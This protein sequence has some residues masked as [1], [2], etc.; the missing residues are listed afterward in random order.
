MYSLPKPMLLPKLP[1]I[2]ST[3][4]QNLSFCFPYKITFPIINTEQI[5]STLYSNT[6]CPTHVQ[7]IYAKTASKTNFLLFQQQ[8]ITKFVQLNIL[9]N[10]NSHLLSHRQKFFL[11][12]AF[13]QKK[14]MKLLLIYFQKSHN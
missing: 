4:M 2:F 8:N 11:Y 6:P 13:P 3:S 7:Q 1:M 14:L 9:S 10:K 5:R 12:S